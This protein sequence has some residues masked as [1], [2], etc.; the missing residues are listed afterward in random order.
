MN[1]QW[2]ET[3]YQSFDHLQDTN[4][5]NTPTNSLSG[6]PLKRVRENPNLSFHYSQYY[7]GLSVKVTRGPLITEWLE[8]MRLSLTEQ[9]TLHSKVFVLRIDLTFPSFYTVP[10]GEVLGNDYYGRFK[11]R[12]R[13][14]LNDVNYNRSHGL[15][16]IAAREYDESGNK[17]HFHLMVI[18]NGNAI[19]S[20]G[21]WDV[22]H[23][24]LYARLHYAWAF[25]LGL[26]VHEVL[27]LIQFCDGVN[28]VGNQR[29]QSKGGAFLLHRG[30]Q[31]MLDDVFFACSYLTKYATKNFNDGCHPFLC[32]KLK[33]YR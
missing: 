11:R 4:N 18:L 31:K 10:E 17:P 28:Y 15:K 29:E 27:G 12:L 13:S 21:T 32:T 33:L 20:S 30:D 8:K 6:E 22:S 24:N 1:S 5:H 25:A 23:D 16:L 7:Q 2:R 3:M 19:N 26:H 14:L 9:L